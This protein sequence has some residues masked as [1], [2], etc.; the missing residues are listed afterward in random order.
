[1]SHTDNSQINCTA[2]FLTAHLIN[3]LNVLMHVCDDLGGVPNQ[4]TLSCIRIKPNDQGSQPLKVLHFPA[5][6]Y[7]SAYATL[8]VPGTLGIT[9]LI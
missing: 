9:I 4:M 7:M 3:V 2:R 6:L 5:E 8:Y 1:M